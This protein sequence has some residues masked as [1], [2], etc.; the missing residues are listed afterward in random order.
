[1]SS[2]NESDP[3]HPSQ[4]YQR[5]LE[6]RRAYEK[7]SQR[8]K[9]QFDTRI[10]KLIEDR[11]ECMMMAS[12]HAGA[13][14]LIYIAETNTYSKYVSDIERPP[15][16]PPPNR[17]EIPEPKK[18]TLPSSVSTFISKF[19][20][21][22][23]HDAHYILAIFPGL[24]VGFGLVIL[25]G[26]PYQRIP[27]ILPL[28]LLI[29]CA[30]LLGLKILLYHFWHQV[31][32]MKAVRA[33]STLTTT[34]LA[35]LSLLLIFAE[36]ALGATALMKFSE[37]TAITASERMNFWI[38]FLVAMAISSPIVLVSAVIGWK[39]GSQAMSPSSTETLRD[40]IDQEH[41]LAIQNHIESTYN[42]KLSDWEKSLLRHEDETRKLLEKYELQKAEL[43]SYRKLPDYQALMKFIGRIGVLTKIIDESKEMKGSESISRGFNKAS[44]Q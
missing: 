22:F 35:F 21:W 12:N 26:L 23:L 5:T 15:V 30:V 17:P 25:T 20:K 7:E 34:L 41:H 43:E 36:V 37:Q 32:S 44:V 11:E 24:F 4:Q 38:A 8:R 42:V 19:K 40:K 14:G 33:E 10:L 6:N 16:I 29:G 1:M 3:S 2:H 28:G 18:R 13:I 27:G 9:D 31:G 39:D